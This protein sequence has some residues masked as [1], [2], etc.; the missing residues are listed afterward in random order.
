MLPSTPIL[1][2]VVASGI[3]A[4]ESDLNLA[5]IASKMEGSRLNLKRFPGLIIRKTKP[6]GTIILF[7]SNKFLLVGVTSVEECETLARKIAKDIRKITNSNI[8]LKN[9]RVTNLVAHAS[10]GTQFINI[11]YKVNVYSLAEE[12]F[13][14]KDDKFPGVYLR[15]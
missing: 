12:C 3:L 13:A 9:F 11:G 2:N 1:N 8:S 15:T 10:L 6:K 4:N 14:F 5:Y 7:K